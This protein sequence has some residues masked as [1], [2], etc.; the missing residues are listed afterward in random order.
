MSKKIRNERRLKLLTITI[1]L[2]MGLLLAEISLRIFFPPYRVS[3][4]GHRYSNNA[5]VYGWGYSPGE[6]FALSNPDT[7][8]IYRCSVN[9]HG[10]RD[11]EHSYENPSGAYRILI[12]G[13]SNTFGPSVPQDKTYPR[14]LEGKLRDRGFNV[15][16]ISIAYG[17][18][19]TDQELE[20]LK[21]DG[22][23]YKPDLI[24]LQFSVNDITDNVY[25][26]APALGITKPFYYRL[27]EDMNLVREDNPKFDD[28][29]WSVSA[30]RKRLKMWSLQSEVLARLYGL[31][32]WLKLVY[33]PRLKRYL[34]VDNQI[35]QIQVVFGISDSHPLIR[36]L[37]AHKERRLDPEKLATVVSAAGLEKSQD[38]IFRICENRWF[39]KYWDRSFY[40]VK[41]P[42]PKADDWQL[43][44]ALLKRIQQLSEKNGAQ[45]AVYSGTDISRFEWDVYRGI[46]RDT[47][48][49]RENHLRMRTLVEEFARANGIAV[50]PNPI[51]L[52]RK[53]STSI[54]WL[55]TSTT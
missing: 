53:I 34:V 32:S 19:G 35:E 44:F 7:G 2:A 20:A 41:P 23:N 33:L 1:G 14:V 51:P 52:W 29:G 26:K 9:S 25:Y 38:L 6:Q 45:L 40:D 37:V 12:L 36:Y 48:A 30:S 49:N 27:N 21:N 50:V 3:T 18:W 13:D 4:I 47:A 5:Q 11:K 43:F 42:D 17:G 24:I 31:Y 55:T 22:L 8:E 28:N 39:N 54:S 16:V 10:W 46:T 15:E